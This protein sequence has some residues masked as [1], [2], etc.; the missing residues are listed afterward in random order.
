MSINIR[1]RQ[2]SGWGCN[3]GLRCV[4]P[5]NENEEFIWRMAANPRAVFPFPSD[6]RITAKNRATLNHK[7]R[8]TK[9]EIANTWRPLNCQPCQSADETIPARRETARSITSLS[10]PSALRRVCVVRWKINTEANFLLDYSVG[11]LSG[12]VVSC[13]NPTMR[14]KSNESN[15]TGWTI[16]SCVSARIRRMHWTCNKISF[17]EGFV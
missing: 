1:W 6:R 2:C 12:R 8:A 16:G 11:Q 17:L 14:R 4:S 5:P 13:L 15:R 7:G 3:F 10:V 9:I